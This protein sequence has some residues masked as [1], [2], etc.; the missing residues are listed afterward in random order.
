MSPNAPT[1]PQ[2]REFSARVRTWLGRSAL[3]ALVVFIGM[4]VYGLPQTPITV[5]LKMSSNG[6]E[7]GE[8][9][10]RSHGDTFTQRDSTAFLIAEDGKPHDYTIK[11]P[12]NKPIDR[13]RIDPTSTKGEIAL[14]SLEIIDTNGVQHLDGRALFKARGRVNQARVEI[15]GNGA[16]LIQ[17][18]GSDPY[19]ELSLHRP[20]GG[21]HPLTVALQRLV[22]A[23]A[24]SLLLTGICAG[25]TY[26]RTLSAAHRRA[27]FLAR[28][29]H[30][31]DLLEFT[32]SVI[33][34]FAL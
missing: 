22:L 9:F 23:L 6:G 34:A 21:P 12:V 3:F 31:D 26:A 1:S 11:L 7:R 27:P 14:Y 29:G 5:Q 15:S 32:P 4:Y 19:I 28:A 13:I 2:S 16:L 25:I 18:V 24:A 33:A 17:S 10:Y 8:I 30:V 20:A